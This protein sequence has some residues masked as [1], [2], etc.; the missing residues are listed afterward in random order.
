MARK[1]LM[2]TNAVIDYLGNKLPSNAAAMLDE[3]ELG[4]SVNTRMELLA[5]RNATAQQIS[6]LKEFI[7][8][9]IIHNLEESVILGGIELRKNYRIKLPD[10]IIAATALVYDL[11]LV[12]RNIDDF[13][14]LEGIDLINPWKL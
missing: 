2:D 9:T 3:E 10:A 12:T 13:K 11:T 6:I 8:S 14:N 5:W 4:I 1:Y 7:D